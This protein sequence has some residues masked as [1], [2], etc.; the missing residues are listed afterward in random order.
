MLTPK[1]AGFLCEHRP[2]TVSRNRSR[3]SFSR[4]LPNIARRWIPSDSGSR[5]GRTRTSLD[6]G[7]V[8]RPG[9][10]LVEAAGG[11]PSMRLAAEL[12]FS[13]AAPSSS[14]SIAST[15]AC[16]P[17]STRA[18]DRAPVSAPNGI[19]NSHGPKLFPTPSDRRSRSKASP[20]PERVATEL[21]SSS[22]W[23]GDRL[24]DDC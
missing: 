5:K 6:F 12:S 24:P 14:G 20:R 10:V 21:A 19:T 7:I 13:A 18:E 9:V 22:A 1:F 15:S 4:R 11:G 16:R 23:K 8:R 3:V 2:C 17:A